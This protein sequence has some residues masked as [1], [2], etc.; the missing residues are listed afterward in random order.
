MPTGMDPQKMR[1]M[2]AIL[3]GLRDKPMDEIIDEIAQMIKSG[4]AGIDKTQARR[5]MEM[6]RPFLTDEQRKAMTKLESRIR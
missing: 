4:D 2:E 6:I 3:R 1:E 5:M